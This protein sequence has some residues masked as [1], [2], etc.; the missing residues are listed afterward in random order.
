MKLQLQWIGA[1]GSQASAAAPVGRPWRGK[2]GRIWLA[3]ALA[4]ALALGATAGFVA[5]GRS[6][7][8]SA[9]VADVSYRPL[10]FEEGFVFAA[11]F[12][13]DGR[14]IV[15]SADWDGQPRDVFVTS[16]DSLDFRP[17]G[18]KGADLLAVSRSGELAILTGSHLPEG[19]SYYRAGTLARG[20]LTGGAPRPELEDVRFAD[21]GRDGALAVVRNDGRQST[22]EYPVGQVLAKDR[23]RLLGPRVSPSGEHVAFF[24]ARSPGRAHGQDLRPVREARG[25]DAVASLTGGGWPGPP[26]T[27]SGTRP[28]NGAACRRRCSG[29]T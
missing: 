1:G 20:S 3:L 5:R 28:W 11:R 19:S 23:Y 22:M 27:S 12:A 9:G 25:R 14:T 6:A 18:F 4:G 10:T 26:E 13:P 16:L 21:F 17:L 24:E 29:S 2:G 15:Y 8:T 7:P